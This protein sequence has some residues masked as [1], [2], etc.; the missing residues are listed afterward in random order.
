[1]K[2]ITRADSTLTSLIAYT[3]IA[4]WNGLFLNMQNGGSIVIRAEIFV[5][6]HFQR[7]GAGNLEWRKKNDSTTPVEKKITV[8]LRMSIDKHREEKR[9]WC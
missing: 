4:G 8:T 1:M 3:D 5:A 2:T 9:Q 6:L 7:N